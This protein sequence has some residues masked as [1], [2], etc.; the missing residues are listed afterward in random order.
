MGVFNL[1]PKEKLIRCRVQLTNTHPFFGR[2]VMSLKFIEKKA[3]GT[4]GVN[5]Y[6]VLYYNPDFVDK[7]SQDELKAVLAH[8]VLHCAF[9]HF[10]EK[11]KPHH[12]IA[13]I[14]EDL[15]INDNLTANGFKLPQQALIPDY[16]HDFQIKLPQ[17]K[18]H[19]VS[20]IDKRTSYDLYAEVY[21]IWKDNKQKGDGGQ[22]K[23]G[24]QKGHDE[25][26]RGDKKGKDSQGVSH[27]D[28]EYWKN[29]I[30]ESY[31]AA[32]Q[33]GKTPAGIGR[34]VEKITHP[35]MT[36]R[37]MLQRFIRN[38]IP[39][40]F[41]WKRPNKRSYSCGWY[42]PKT[43]K[44]GVTIVLLIDTS[45][46][47]SQKELEQIFGEMHG[48][49]EQVHGL[50]LRVIYH[51]TKVYEGM[52][53]LNPTLQDVKAEFTKAKGGGGTDFEYAYKW[54]E[55]NITDTDM[56]IHCTDGYDR[57]PQK[58]SLPL[59]ILLCGHSKNVK[60]VKEECKYADF[61]VKVEDKE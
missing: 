20:D 59:I 25:H 51:D 50:D 23:G 18:T 17:G 6:G 4:M 19:T 15:V 49:V 58:F 55:D 13:N 10:D 41:T 61:V 27:R 24:W 48:I 11:H 35:K 52:S 32:K 36:W 14:V 42:M 60:D 57:F 21:K 40:D 16:N 43:Q 37:Q 46:S 5:K 39:Y 34:M 8:E 31:M 54:L 29:K 45:G 56:V 12:Q 53:K 44:E 47:I 2:L 7:L 3:V 9:E 22:G 30:V 38:R 1:T 26:M 28:S 33:A